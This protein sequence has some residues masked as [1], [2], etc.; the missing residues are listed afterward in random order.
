MNPSSVYEQI[1]SSRQCIPQLV[2]KVRQKV[3]RHPRAGRLLVK[4]AQ[5]HIMFVTHGRLR[6][7]NT[8]ALAFV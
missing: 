5:E 3:L 8:E 2:L 6:V 1:G 4:I 7:E